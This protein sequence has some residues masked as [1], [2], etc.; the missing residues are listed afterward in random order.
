MVKAGGMPMGGMGMGGR[1]AS[2][3]NPLKK[4]AP[5]LRAVEA[6]E[7]LLK[8]TPAELDAFVNAMTRSAIRKPFRPGAI[9][10]ASTRNALRRRKVSQ[11]ESSLPRN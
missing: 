11:S 1:R 9:S 3:E 2:G 5:E 4:F 10:T 7:N 8:S 6:Y